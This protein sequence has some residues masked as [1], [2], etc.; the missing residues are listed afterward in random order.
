V[1]RWGT[2]FGLWIGIILI[3]LYYNNKISK[4]NRRLDIIGK[5]IG[6]LCAICGYFIANYLCGDSILDINTLTWPHNYEVYFDRI[7]AQASQ[8]WKIAAAVIS[9]YKGVDDLL[10]IIRIK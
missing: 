8:S 2:Y 6:W 1:L 3:G 7:T 4:A 5:Y 9:Y 10:K